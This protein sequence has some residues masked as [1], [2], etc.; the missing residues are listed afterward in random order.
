MLRERGRA[1]V[2]AS[3]G[4]R[5]A[6]LGESKDSFGHTQFSAS[7]NTVAQMLVTYLNHVG[8]AAKEAPAS[9]CPARTSATT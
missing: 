3:E 2:V 4:L 6:T 1:I 5:W 7:D 9:T 8:L